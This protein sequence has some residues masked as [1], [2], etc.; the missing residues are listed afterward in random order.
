MNYEQFV[1]W[2]SGYISSLQGQMIT[3]DQ[4][5]GICNLVKSI[6]KGDEGIIYSGMLSE[7]TR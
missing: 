3:E 4:W 6:K 7:F 5:Q 1:Y 2:F